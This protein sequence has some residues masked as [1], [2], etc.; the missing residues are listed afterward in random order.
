MNLVDCPQNAAI[1]TASTPHHSPQNGEPSGSCS[2]GGGASCSPPRYSAACLTH[3]AR[4]IVS[5]H[6]Q[7]LEEEQGGVEVHRE[8]RPAEF[9]AHVRQRPRHD[10]PGDGRR[11]PPRAAAARPHAAA[12]HQQPAPDPP[13]PV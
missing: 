9:H 8:E 12:H 3:S 4:L 2:H 13:C 5:S 7:P 11:R 10:P 1:T 6:E